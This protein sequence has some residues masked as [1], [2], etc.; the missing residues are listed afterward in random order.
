[1]INFDKLNQV[2]I[3]SMC[4]ESGVYQLFFESIKNN[5]DLTDEQI[6]EAMIKSLKSS[7]KFRD[8]LVEVLNKEDIKNAFNNAASNMQNKK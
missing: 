8:E 2:D 5:T 6:H 1:M 7:D 4:K 3:I